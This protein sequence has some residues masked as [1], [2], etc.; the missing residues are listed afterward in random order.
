VTLSMA[1]S[2]RQF[3]TSH[4]DHLIRKMVVIAGQLCGRMPLPQ[5][6]DARP[7]RARRAPQRRALW[8]N[9]ARWRG[10]GVGPPAGDTAQVQS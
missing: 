10:S 4:W 6:L 3:M 9:F 1:R 2:K 7:R 8:L 5:A